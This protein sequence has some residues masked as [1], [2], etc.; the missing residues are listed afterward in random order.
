[1]SRPNGSPDLLLQVRELRKSFGGLMAVNDVSLDLEEGKIMGVIGPN[2]AG[3]S[4]FFNLIT[5]FLRPDTG[6]IVFE[7]RDLTGNP[8]HLI[9]RQGIARTFQNLQ[10]FNNMTVLENVMMGRYLQSRAGIFSTALRLPR[11]R[12]EEKS[13]R[14]AALERLDLMGLADQAAKTPA[15]LPYGQQ[16]MLE[17]ARALAVEP[18]LLLIDEPAGGLSTT[19]IEV[20]A[21]L[22]LRIREQ[23]VTIILVEHRM[24]LVMG[25]TD[26]IMVLN[27]GSK[28]AE[29][30]PAEIQN[31]EEVV[32]AYLGED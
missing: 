16:K 21:G 13:I 29:G 12:R 25:I 7:G 4:T 3:K 17:M 27:F 6:R 23:G 22:I 24:E 32:T 1:M 10:L 14:A 15:N 31:N 8:A 30:T 20:L 5:G 26:R 11:A 18:K 2:G 28:I 19:E 9:A